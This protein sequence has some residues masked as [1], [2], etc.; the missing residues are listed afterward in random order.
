MASL[1][2]YPECCAAFFQE[3][4]IEQ[5]LVDTTW[6]MA[7]ATTPPLDG[8][9]CIE[10]S[11]PAEANIL[12]R[13]MGIRAVSHLPCRFDCAASVALSRRLMTVG[14]NA[15]YATEMGWLTEILSWPVQWSAL[16]GVAEIK[17]P[18]LKVS[19]CTD[20]TPHELVVKYLGSGYPEEGA[21]GVAFPF[22]APARPLVTGSVGYIRGMQHPIA[23]LE[24]PP[25]WYAA[26]NGFA[27]VSTMD[28]AHLPVVTLA[29]AALGGR[30]GPVLDLGCG[31]GALLAK[32]CAANSGIEPF[33]VDNNP[34]RV[35]HAAVLLP[36]FTGNF[37][38]GDMFAC[39]ALWPEGRRYA[40]ALLMPGRVLEASAASAS[41]LLAHLRERCDQV[42]V[43]AYGD[44]LTRYGG[45]EELARRAGLSLSGQNRGEAVA[46]AA[47]A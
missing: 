8:D 17:T 22:R 6:L 28:E 19:T 31:N 9:R 13:W 47:T 4:W 41:R 5:Q 27:S 34:A 44:W 14:R 25:E 40:L 38:A 30:A 23:A 33:G 36:E 10:L 35:S 37:V 11:G 3:V 20:A 32:L 21:R 12:W 29:L 16:H 7:A 24:T 39:E 42:L 45:V 26:D 1:L 2:G 43:Y 46:L 18:L 15:G